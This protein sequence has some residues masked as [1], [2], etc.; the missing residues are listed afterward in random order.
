[1]SLTWSTNPQHEVDGAELITKSEAR[2]SERIP[3]RCWAKLSCETEAGSG[4]TIRGHVLNVGASGVLLEALTPI[5]VG[6]K[7]RIHA[8]E[9]LSGIAYVRHSTRRAWRFKIG[10]EF[11]AAVQNSY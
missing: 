11:A 6:S 10:L 2:A 8:N 5:A 4:R 9:L 1:M 7:V 3:M